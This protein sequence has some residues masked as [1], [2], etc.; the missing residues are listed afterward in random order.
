[1]KRQ[2]EQQ[3]DQESSKEAEK[4]KLVLAQ[5]AQQGVHL[6]KLDSV[7]TPE[8]GLVWLCPGNFIVKAMYTGVSVS[9]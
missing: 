1:L 9:E 3:K 5:L 2:Q 8:S 4:E 6:A 7:S